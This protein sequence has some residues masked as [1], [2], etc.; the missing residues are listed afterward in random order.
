MHN[1]L[2]E[3]ALKEFSLKRTEYLTEQILVSLSASLGTKTTIF[4]SHSHLDSGLVKN[5]VAFLKALNADVYIDWLDQDMPAET[6]PETAK[7]LKEK[8]REHDKFILLATKNS[9]ESKW[10]P[11]ELGYADEVK[12]MR[13]IAILPIAESATNYSGTE[14]VGIYPF[15]RKRFGSDEWIV[16]CEDPTIFK[17]LSDW[18]T[19]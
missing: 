14:F 13:K 4:L 1:Y 11:W 17:E 12:G 3:S 5:A 9:R 2:T 7:K 19:S 6:T 18:L 15:I 10:V 8:I 16:R